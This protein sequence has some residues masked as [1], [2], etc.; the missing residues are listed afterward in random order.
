[1][2]T[3][4]WEDGRHG[5]RAEGWAQPSTATLHCYLHV[6]MSAVH[7]CM[8]ACVFTYVWVHR[9]VHQISMPDV[10]LSH[11]P[12]NILRQGLPLNQGQGFGCPSDSV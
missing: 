12:L 6:R 1:V 5:K 11:F 9:C 4:L 3:R 2:A 8:C 10:F 7:T